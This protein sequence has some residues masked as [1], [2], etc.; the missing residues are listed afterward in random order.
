MN[1]PFLPLP[2]VLQHV[3]LMAARN[4]SCVARGPYGF[5]EAYTDAD[6]DPNRLPPWWHAR[7]AGYI[8]RMWA[9]VLRRDEPLRDARG[10][11]TR[12]HLSFIAWA[13]SPEPVLV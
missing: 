7:R 6:G 2:V 9:Q 5:I 10:R 1:T 3:P 12:R 4:V 13:W 8:A 11:L